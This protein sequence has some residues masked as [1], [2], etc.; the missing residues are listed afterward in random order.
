[1]VYAVTS[2]QRAFRFWFLDHS[3]VI[4]HIALVEMTDSIE[5]DELK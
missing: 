3:S 1:M 4:E 5:S 2:L